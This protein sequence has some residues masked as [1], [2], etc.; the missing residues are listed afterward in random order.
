MMTL[1]RTEFRQLWPLAGLWLMLELLHVALLLFTTRLDESSYSDLCEVYCEPGVATSAIFI[2]LVI[3]VWIGWSLFPRDSDD[4]TLA[5]LQSLAVSRP[6]IF[7]AKVLAAFVLLV[8]LYLFSAATTYFFVWLN[9]QSIHGKYYAAIEGQQLL[10]TLAF[11]AIVLCH[12]VFLSSFRLVGLVLY[13]VY[14]VAVGY[15]ETQLGDV[16]AWNLLNILRVDYY[17]STLVT[18]WT[19]FA[20]HGVIALVFLWLGYLRWM[21]RDVS[22]QSA[23]F[24]LNSPWLTVPAVGLLFLGLLGGLMQHSSTTVTQRNEA[25]DSLTTE[26]YRFVFTKNA[27]PYAEELAAGAD[28]M[29]LRIADYLDADPPPMIQT[30]L[31]ANTSHVA[32]L[33]VHNRIRMRLRRINDDDDNR[34]VLAHETAHVF[35]STMSNRQLKKVNSSVNFFIEGMAQQVAYTVEPNDR[36]RDINW[37]VGAVSA[38]RHDIDFTDLVDASAFGEKFDAELP[39]TLGDLWVNTMTEVC[40]DDSLGKFMNIV[41]SDDAV[42]SLSGVAFWRQHLQRIPCE[43]EDINH[44]F[45][46]RVDDIV[47]SDAAQ[48]IPS[49]KSINL[50]TD[51]TDPDIIW[52]DVIVENPFEL[53]SNDVPTAG[54]DYLLRVR[55]GASLARTIDQIVPGYPTSPDTPERISFRLNRSQFSTNRFQ[56]QIGYQGGFDYRALFDEW[57]NAA[58]PR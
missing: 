25:F 37:I 16:G 54:K 20:I 2:L 36:V 6:Q 5:H 47:A 29:L 4:G 57:Q 22:Q 33:A 31:T 30:D 34:F 17:G 1:F 48:A 40:G 46:E 19:L 26:H 3:V 11:S 49:T 42:L 12:S 51:D 27:A 8:C 38:D 56:Y 7:G 52:M 9:P 24:S 53:D 44:R 28:A 18:N 55:S 15:L 45:G 50:R 35:Q 58:V 41:G 32:G 13:A 21:K 23:R 14:F 43:L 10:R 39:Y